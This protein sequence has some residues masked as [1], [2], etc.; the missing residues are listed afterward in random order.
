MGRK[1]ARILRLPDGSVLFLCFD[2]EGLI[3]YVAGDGFYVELIIS[4]SQLLQ[5]IEGQA[6]D[7]V[8]QPCAHHPNDPAGAEVGQQHDAIEGFFAGDLHH[9]IIIERVREYRNFS[10][11]DHCTMVWVLLADQF[12]GSA[13]LC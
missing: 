9:H 6:V 10:S 7:A 2:Q 8:L 3:E 13:Y 4:C 12:G 11:Q 1:V 5:V